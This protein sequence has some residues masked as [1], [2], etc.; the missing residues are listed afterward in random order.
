M[1]HIMNN[2]GIRPLGRVSFGGGMVHIKRVAAEERGHALRPPELMRATGSATLKCMHAQAV[3]PGCSNP[4][5]FTLST[6]TFG[7]CPGCP[8]SRCC[9]HVSGFL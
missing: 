5:S 9:S 6:L 7:E 4:R 2:R 3:S 8:T 1:W